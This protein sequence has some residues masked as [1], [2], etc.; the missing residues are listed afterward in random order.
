MLLKIIHISFNFE[1]LFIR[2]EL[3]IFK[4]NFKSSISPFSCIFE[5]IILIIENYLF[6]KIHMFITK[7]FYEDININIIFVCIIYFVLL[8]KHFSILFVLHI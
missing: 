8:Y 2:K 1:K 4:Q 6:M 7:I 3:P 5:Y